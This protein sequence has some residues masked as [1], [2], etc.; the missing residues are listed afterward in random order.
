MFKPVQLSSDIYT[1]SPGGKGVIM[2]GGIAN[3]YNEKEDNL[4]KMKSNQL[5]VLKAKAQN[6]VQLKQTLKNARYWS[7][8]IPLYDNWGQ[9]IPGI[10]QK[11]VHKSD[12][13]ECPPKKKVKR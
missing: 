4:T 2:I 6:W 8:A 12:L 5:W 11:F 3:Y 10:D 9:T 13:D 7:V 1:V